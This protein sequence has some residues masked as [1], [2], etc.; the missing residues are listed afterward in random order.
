[1]PIIPNFL[2]IALSLA[3]HLKSA[4]LINF[5]LSL[6]F[7]SFHCVRFSLLEAVSQS[8]ALPSGTASFKVEP[9]VEVGPVGTG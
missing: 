5:P 9:P 1:M 4:R 2:D 7:T 6:Y 8:P 3:Y